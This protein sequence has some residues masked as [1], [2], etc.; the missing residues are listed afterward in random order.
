MFSVV[1]RL[2]TWQRSRLRHSTIANFM[3]YK[4]AMNLEEGLLKLEEEEDLLVPEMHAKIPV[5]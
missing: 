2:A 3:M 1:G 5:K 4:A